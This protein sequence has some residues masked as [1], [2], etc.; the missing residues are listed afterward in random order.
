MNN[1]K[2]LIEDALIS[3]KNLDELI[4]IKMKERTRDGLSD[5]AAKG[6]K[7]NIGREQTGGYRKEQ[8]A[9]VYVL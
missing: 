7:H 6:R 2:Q 4:K 9:D 5:D 1:K 8:D 3:G